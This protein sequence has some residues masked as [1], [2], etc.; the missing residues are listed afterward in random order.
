MMVLYG[1]N[2][3]MLRNLLI[4][5]LGWIVEHFLSLVKS[6]SKMESLGE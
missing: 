3:E 1:D 6:L 5:L 4:Y 2:S